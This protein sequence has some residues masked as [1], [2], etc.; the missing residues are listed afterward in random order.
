MTNIIEPALESSGFHAKRIDMHP[1]P[2]ASIP[3]EI[4]K[5]LRESHLCVAVLTGLNPNVMF[6]VGVRQAWDLPILHLV[7]DDTQ[8]PF[9]IASR[10]TVFYNLRSKQLVEKAVAEL[11]KRAKLVHKQ[12]METPPHLVPQVSQIFATSMRKLS[13]KYL[14][15][16]VC[17]AKRNTIRNI[18]DE[19]RG[20]VSLIEEDFERN[21]PHAKPLKEFVDQIAQISR[22]LRDKTDVY[23]EIAQ[24]Q[25]KDNGSRK[26]VEDV[27]E[28]FRQLQRDFDR[29]IRQLYD[30]SSSEDDFVAA[31][32]S[33]NAII[34]KAEI[35]ESSCLSHKLPT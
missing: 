26:R 24:T 17:E 1:P 5:A 14:M 23:R 34:T 19:F 32:E 11:G 10:D 9:D 33:I 16:P 4:V 29:L 6:E 18:C 3:A 28:M 30:A 12:W 13:E 7:K 22:T 31:I 20:L 25:Q 35:I 27:L 8:L 2:G 15:D 21:H